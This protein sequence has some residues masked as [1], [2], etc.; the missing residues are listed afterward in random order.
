MFKRAFKKVYEIRGHRHPLHKQYLGWS[1]VSNSLASMQY[2]MSTHSMLSVLG[3]TSS[4][5]AFSASYVGK[6]IFGQLGGVIYMNRVGKK[7]DDDPGKFVNKAL[8]IQQCAMAVECITPM[9]P[10]SCFVPV[11]G[12]ANISQNVA[13]TSIGAINAK[14]IQRLAPENVGEM[15]AKISMLNTLGST[16]GMTLGLGLVYIVPC[17][18]SRLVFVP[19]LA[20]AR[21]YTYKRAIK[22]LVD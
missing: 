14:I 6:D 2:V 15:Y 22:G 20:A 3:D 9:L 13:S 7:A 17:H 10:L 4:Q 11:A 19:F 1:I 12:L 5:V 16:I 8:M 21:V 18:E